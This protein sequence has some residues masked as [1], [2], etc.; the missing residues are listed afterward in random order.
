VI[1]IE[2]QDC[3]G[4]VSNAV[5]DGGCLVSHGEP[6]KASLTM[7]A[8]EEKCTAQ[9]RTVVGAALPGHDIQRH[10]SQVL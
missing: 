6:K 1:R 2:G 7:I 8:I 4:I 9:L 10:K 5:G 3:V